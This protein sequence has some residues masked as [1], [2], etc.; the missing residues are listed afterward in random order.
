M[1]RFWLPLM[2]SS[3]FILGTVW[4]LVPPLRFN[5]S[6]SM[7]VGVYRL[8]SERP[9]RNALVMFCLEGVWASLAR[10]RDYL[11]EG[12]CPA[13]QQ[14][15]LKEVMALEG[16]LVTVDAMGVSV[17][18]HL[19][20][21][22]R[23]RSSDSKGRALGSSLVEGTVPKSHALVM[24][25]TPQSFDGRYFGLLPMAHLQCVEPLFTLNSGEHHD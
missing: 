24:G 7:P 2:L 8:C 25:R 23:T 18:G 19:L 9:A 22:S 13:G 5:L 15:L 10:G 17:N 21:N 6:A 3:C 4:L 1:P 16:D 12:T 14:P 11:T 20:A